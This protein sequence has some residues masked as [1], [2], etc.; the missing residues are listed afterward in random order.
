MQFIK[1]LLFGHPI[2]SFSEKEEQEKGKGFHYKNQEYIHHSSLHHRETAFH[3]LS[4]PQI[5]FFLVA[6]VSIVVAYFIN[7]HLSLIVTIACLTILYFS[8]LLFNLYLIYR[9]FSKPAEIKIKNSDIQERENWPMYTILCPLY[10]EWVVIPQFIDS[11]KK[12]AYPS[13]K[14]QIMLLLEEDDTE[15]VTK[16][17]EYSLPS[18]FSVVVIPHSKPKT[19]P[20][21]CNYGLLQAT[22]EYVVIYDAEDVPDPL[23]LKKAVI[24]FENSDDRVKCVQAKLNFYN[25]HQNLISRIFTAEYSL[26]FELVLTGLQSIHA[27]IPL[28]GTSNHFRK[29]DLIELGGW[30]SFNVTEDCDLGM[31]LVKK[32]Y[33][34]AIIESLTLEEANSNA[35]NW[36]EQ[37]TRWIKG[38]MQTY[39]LH[40]RRPQEFIQDWKEP[41]V[42]TFQLV[43]G[44]KVLS[45]FINPLMWGITIAYFLFR[46][47]IGVFIE[48]LFPT[49]IL[50]MGL[51]SIFLGNFLYLYYYIIGCIKHGHYDLV[52]YAIFVPFYWLAM[53][54]AAW[55]A[56]YRL[57]VS[58]HYWSKTKHGLHL[59]KI[60]ENE[61]ITSSSSLP[62]RIR[63]ALGSLL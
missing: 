8:D 25:P 63:F 42:I 2:I 51:I 12:L 39:L 29:N 36:F 3:R 31:R 32:G 9:S 33:R 4:R 27:P 56:F 1:N 11:M 10:K 55:V 61:V 18:N 53:S 22:G 37:R 7:W 5:L 34:T 20:K 21:A 46:A 43:V 15:S 52:K 19:K 35:L 47:H 14:L 60:A 17:R 23:Q 49:P 26:W 38:Y 28:G 6:F 13:N 40:M 30:D 59:E 50:L 44:G 62:Q 58:P 41:H 45:M 54:V 57:I 24:A 48:S 16:I